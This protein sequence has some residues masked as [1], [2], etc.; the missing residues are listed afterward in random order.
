MK[1]VILLID[2]DQNYRQ[3]CKIVLQGYGFEVV[4]AETGLRG[5]F[6]STESSY[7]LILMD[8]K[9]AEIPALELLSFIKWK[10]DRKK[11]AEFKKRYGDLTEDSRNRDTPVVILTALSIGEDVERAREAGAEDVLLKGVDNN[12]LK[13]KIQEAINNSKLRREK[14]V[15]STEGLFVSEDVVFKKILAFIDKIA[16]SNKPVLITGESGVGKEVIARLIW[17]KSCRHQNVFRVCNCT[18]VTKEMVED[19]LFG[20]TKGAFTGATSERKGL[21]KSAQGGTVFLDEIAETGMEFQA[22]LL[23]ALQF[24][25]IQTVGSDIVDY[26]DVRFLAATNRDLEKEIA[27]SRF[28]HDLYYRFTFTIHIPPLRE[29]VCDLPRLTAY[30]L[31]KAAKEN[32][33]PTPTV[34]EEAMRVICAYSWPGNIRQLQNALEYA[35]VMASGREIVKDDLPDYI[36]GTTVPIY[37]PKSLDEVEKQAIIEALR[38][39]SWVKTRASKILDITPKTLRDKLDKYKLVQPTPL[40]KEEPKE[41]VDDEGDGEGIK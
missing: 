22:K 3:T 8:L 21:L 1:P 4:T 40:G 28:R 20:H 26:V 37:Q 6:L 24:G 25:E 18:G 9:F 38:Y 41:E 30:L 16:D 2:G 10:L 12:V 23:R 39:T 14:E 13:L 17:Q 7:D 15:A 11:N 29:R 35:S 32:Q 33:K 36:S 19:T 34:S 5:A 27:Q 31:E